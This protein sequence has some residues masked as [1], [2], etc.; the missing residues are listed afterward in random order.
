MLNTRSWD[1]LTYVWTAWRNVTG[2]KMR[3]KIADYVELSNKAAQANGEDNSD[4]IGT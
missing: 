1:E 3:E 4:R 2:R